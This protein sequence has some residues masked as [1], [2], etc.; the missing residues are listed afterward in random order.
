MYKKG[1]KKKKKMYSFSIIVVTYHGK[2]TVRPHLE[3]SCRTST[4][5]EGAAVRAGSIGMFIT[6]GSLDHCGAAVAEPELRWK[7]GI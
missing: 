6:A 7:S 5:Q 2:W 1:V 4:R 3:G